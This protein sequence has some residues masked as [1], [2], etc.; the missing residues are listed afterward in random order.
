MA[1]VGASG[2]GEAGGLLLLVAQSSASVRE[3]RLSWAPCGTLPASS[4][5]PHSHLRGE[6][7][8]CRPVLQM[9]RLRRRLL[10]QLAHIHTACH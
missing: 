2:G 3:A 5:N 6:A 10:W 8:H 7:S 1:A 4:C 9:R